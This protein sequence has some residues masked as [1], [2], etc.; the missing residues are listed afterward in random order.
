[1]LGIVGNGTAQLAY[2]R[3]LPTWFERRGLAR[4]NMPTGS[5]TDSIV[6]PILAQHVIA[7]YGRVQ[8]SNRQ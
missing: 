6:L 2:S 1:M 7:A 4:A 8:V 5:G 3:A